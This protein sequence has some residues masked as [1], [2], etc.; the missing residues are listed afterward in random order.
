MTEPLTVS[1]NAASQPLKPNS[2]WN[3]AKTLFKE[4]IGAV[5]MNITPEGSVKIKRLKQSLF[6]HSSKA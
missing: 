4:K 1:T 6:Q 2:S 5:T 3:W